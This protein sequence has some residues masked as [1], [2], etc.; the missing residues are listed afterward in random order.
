MGR[1]KHQ[2]I[3]AS[4]KQLLGAGFAVAANANGSTHA[5]ATVRVLA[6]VGV[7]LHLVDVFH[8]DEAAQEA[9]LVHHQQL[10]DTVLVQV[11]LGFLKRGSHGHGNKVCAGHH[12]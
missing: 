10:F 1:I 4:F 9:L 12:L 8:G 3:C 2:H 11:T 6:G 7:L 5:Q